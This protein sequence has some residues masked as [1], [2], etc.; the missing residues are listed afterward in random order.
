MP[1]QGNAVNDI[2][3]QCRLQGSETPWMEFKKN[4]SDPQEIG[5]YISALS[6]SAAL[7]SQTCAFLIWGIDDKTHDIVGTGFNPL[8]TKVGNQG[9][10]LW[11]SMH[12]EPKIQFYFHQTTICGKKVVLLEIGAA[13]SV[14][15]R[16]KGVDYIRIDSY[17]NLRVQSY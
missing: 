8:T 16:F 5:E 12:L 17:K 13:N 1:F 9:L 3:E 15:V 11:L 14:P 6:N 2:I 10:E 4:N 7:F